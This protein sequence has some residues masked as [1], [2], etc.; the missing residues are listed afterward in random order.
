MKE[1]ISQFH[2]FKRGIPLFNKAVTIGQIIH[3]H[4]IGQM[5]LGR[6]SGLTAKII[7]ILYLPLRRASTNTKPWTLVRRHPNQF[8]GLRFSLGT[9][10][11]LFSLL[12]FGHHLRFQRALTRLRN[13]Q[14]NQT[15][16][17][18][19]YIPSHSN[20]SGTAR[21]CTNT[22]QNCADVH[23]L[24]FKFRQC[25]VGP[26]ENDAFTRKTQQNVFCPNKDAYLFLRQFDSGGRKIWQRTVNF[27]IAPRFLRHVAQ[28]LGV[29][30]L[31]VFRFLTNM[32]HCF[33][34]L[35][36]PSQKFLDSY[37]FIVNFS[38]KN[39]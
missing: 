21:L 5:Q 14:K 3:A 23:I 12:S 20:T 30:Y 22:R 7:I 29:I 39:Q 1:S 10:L 33:S 32:V 27:I 25:F 38:D 17:S 24:L 13:L 4:H 16:F 26:F 35:S 34:S 6:G 19:L 11:S 28:Q 15:T 31:F 2:L 9:L 36:N 18:L 8:P 37:D